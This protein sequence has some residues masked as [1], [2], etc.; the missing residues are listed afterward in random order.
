MALAYQEHYLIEDYEQWE[1]EWELIDG[2][3]YA[4]APAPVTQ[5]QFLAT[6]VAAQLNL[7]LDE[8]DA[9]YAVAEAEWRVREETRSFDPT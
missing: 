3:P 4:M 9:C 6:Q 5:H 8:C 1:G 7:A 2:M